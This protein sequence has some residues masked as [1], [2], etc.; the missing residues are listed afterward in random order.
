MNDFVII[1]TLV[2]F[3]IGKGLLKTFLRR[4]LPSV[5]E[6]AEVPLTKKINMTG[7]A[8]T[9]VN[10]NVF[11]TNI[12]NETAYNVGGTNPAWTRPSNHNGDDI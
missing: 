11:V 6:W 10:G 8:F 1:G 3:W 9:T 4:V 2:A 5:C 7:G 12:Q